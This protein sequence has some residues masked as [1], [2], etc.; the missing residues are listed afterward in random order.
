MNFN[1][2]SSQPTQ[3]QVETKQNYKPK[4]GISIQIVRSKH[5]FEHSTHYIES[6]WTVRPKNMKDKAHK[7]LSLIIENIY[8]FKKKSNKHK[9]KG[10]QENRILFKMS[11]NFDP[12]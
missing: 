5:F 6:Q 2:Q 11:P 8:G 4:H 9:V 12:K 10:S 7:Y 3:Y 1:G